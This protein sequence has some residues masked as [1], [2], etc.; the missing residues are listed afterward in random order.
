MS[1]SVTHTCT[2][3]NG[4]SSNMGN[5]LSGEDGSKYSVPQGVQAELE[6]LRKQLADKDKEL[7]AVK[8][9]GSHVTTYASA[10][11]KGAGAVGQHAGPE[12]MALKQQVCGSALCD[13][14]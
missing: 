4:N 8:P 12:V 10:A 14:P 9:G 6:S 5:C 1:R 7:A 2:T 13:G 11:A 3:P